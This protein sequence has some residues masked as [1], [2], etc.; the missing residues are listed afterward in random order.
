M[1][2]YWIAREYTELH[3][4]TLCYMWVTSGYAGSHEDTLAG[5]HVITRGYMWLHWVIICIDTLGYICG[6]TYTYT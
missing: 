1:S 4:D 2:L 5:L 6:Y 3:V